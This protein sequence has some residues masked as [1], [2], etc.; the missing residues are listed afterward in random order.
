M[1]N[2]QLKSKLKNELTTM[3]YSSKDDKEF[4]RKLFIASNSEVFSKMNNTG[5]EEYL[6]L[7]LSS[8][9]LIKNTIGLV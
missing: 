1:E 7:V 3:L 2:D 8:S 6:N 5:Y 4:I 9:D